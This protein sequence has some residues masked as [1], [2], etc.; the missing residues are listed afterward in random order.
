MVRSTW[1]VIRWG[2]KLML[3]SRDPRVA[4]L[5]PGTTKNVVLVLGQV[6]QL[7][8]PTK[9]GLYLLGLHRRH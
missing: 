3:T 8:N 5:H 2:F 7:E 9:L 6:C 1:S 4:S